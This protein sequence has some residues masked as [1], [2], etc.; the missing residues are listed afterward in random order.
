L[1]TSYLYQAVTSGQFV[2]YL[3]NHAKGAAYPAVVSGDFE[4]AEILVPSQ[5]LVRSFNEIV[6]PMIAQSHCLKQQNQKLRTARDLLLPKLM[7][8]EIA[9]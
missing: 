7:S 1:S 2:G 4:R 5:P 8:G 9:V 3:N 6:E